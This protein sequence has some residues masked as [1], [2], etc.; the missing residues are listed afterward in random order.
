MTVSTARELPED[1]ASGQRADLVTIP[2]RAGEQAAAAAMEQAAAAGN[3]ER[4]PALVAAVG[5]GSS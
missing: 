3:L 2:L 4:A 5:P 1:H